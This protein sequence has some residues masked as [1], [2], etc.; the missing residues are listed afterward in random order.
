MSYIVVVNPAILS[1]PGTNIPFS[2]ALTATVMVCFTMTLLM[3]LYAK[4]PFGVAPG[5][6]LNAFF[7][8]TL[9]INGG[10]AWPVAL[11]ITFWAG[12]VFLLVSITP[13]RERIALAI[14]LPLRSATAGGIGLLLTFIGLQNAGFV[15]ANPAT[16]VGVGPLDHRALLVLASL[17]VSVWLA[18]RDNP[19]AYLAG[20]ALAT[21]GAWLGGFVAPPASWFSAPDFSSVF[22]ELDVWSALQLS[23]VPAMLTVM[24]TDLFDSLSTFIGVSQAATLTDDQGKPKHLRQGL[25]V[26]SFATFGAALF[27]SS[28][29]TAY[30][31][32]IAGI[33]MGG[34]TGRSA[35]ITALCFLPCLFIAPLAAAIPPY[36]T[37][38]VLI[39]VGVAMF[40]SVTVV[41]FDR[42][43]IALPAFATLILIPLT[44][45]ITQGILWG[46]ILHAA[47]HVVAGRRRDVTPAAWGLA[48]V[49]VALLVI[50]NS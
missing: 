13:L 19:F 14:P 2:G 12:V 8:Y 37:S 22:L 32:S 46:F 25:I 27:G 7:A 20:I 34:R 17:I 26:D 29:G 16:M 49:A 42:L 10:I 41:P 3:G 4:L 40:Q 6:G 44:F 31:E 21:G 11:G 38:A 5:M 45:S 48:V 18:R 9:I 28:S 35:V 1:T 36:A 43:E 39:L 30:V 24:L 47:L 15:A 33:R 23:L 50:E